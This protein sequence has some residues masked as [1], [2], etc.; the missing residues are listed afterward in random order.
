M[1][2]EDQF[3]EIIQRAADEM[4]NV[5]CPLDEYLSGLKSARAR[6]AD[7]VQLVTKEIEDAL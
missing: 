4:A 5:E 3:E 7:L 2:A 6:F 1:E